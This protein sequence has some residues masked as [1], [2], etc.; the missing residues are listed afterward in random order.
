MDIKELKLPFVASANSPF[1]TS[2]LSRSA[3]VL[4]N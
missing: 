4:I 2:G 1:D 3:L